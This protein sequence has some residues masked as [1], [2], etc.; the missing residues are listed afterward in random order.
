MEFG[1]HSIEDLSNYLDE[2]SALLAKFTEHWLS[3]T[4]QAPRVGRAPVPVGITLYYAGALKTTQEERNGNTA[5]K[6]FL[7]NNPDLLRQALDAATADIRSAP[8]N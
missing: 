6:A 5:A 3:H 7:A 1:F 8:G 4:D 2:N